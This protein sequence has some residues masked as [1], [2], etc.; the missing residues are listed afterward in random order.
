MEPDGII[1]YSPRVITFLKSAIRGGN[2][3]I[4]GRVARPSGFVGALCLDVDT[5]T[6]AI[7]KSERLLMLGADGTPLAR[8]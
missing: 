7:W 3:A 1:D 5:G 6:L 8:I 2:V 4:L